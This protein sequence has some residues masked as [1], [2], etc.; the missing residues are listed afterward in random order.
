MSWTTNQQA[1]EAVKRAKRTLIIAPENPTPDAQ[2]SVAGLLSFLLAHDIQADAFIPNINIDKLPDYLPKR[3]DIKNNL[4]S[5]R[6]FKISLD[7]ANVPIHELAYDVEDG[8]LNIILT[9]K[10]GEWKNDHVSL[11]PG[12]DRYD[13]IITIGFADRSVMGSA[14]NSHQDFIFRLPIINIDHDAKNEHWAAINMVD[15]TAS[16]STEVI[17][18]WLSDWNKDKIDQNIAT[19]LLAGMIANTQSFKSPKI[20]PK[21]LE[22]A[23]EL[24]AMGADREKIVHQLWRT[25]QVSTLKLWGKALTRLEHDIQNEMIW[26]VLSRQDILESG[27]SE[28]KLDELVNELIA[29]SPN[30]KLVTIFVEHDDKTTKAAIFTQ[31][32]YEADRLGRGLGLD[33][34]KQRASGAIAKPLLEAKDHV[35]KT[36]REQLKK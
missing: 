31:I 18:S 6:D 14:F 8:K 35:I 2:A 11:H 28:A 25:R 21:T 16:S 19:A 3:H 36:L 20:I 4:P 13:L 33:G 27:A 7:V 30:S 1:I 23:A 9:P 29:Y 34:N 5:T 32:P 15:M 12:E 22:R 17:F 24:V 26:T 10:N